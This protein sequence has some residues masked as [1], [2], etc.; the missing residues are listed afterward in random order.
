MAI[1]TIPKQ[2]PK[3]TQEPVKRNE[4]NVKN[5]QKI[6]QEIISNPD[7]KWDKKTRSYK[8][9]KHRPPKP[10]NYMAGD[11]ETDGLFGPFIAA[12]IAIDNNPDNVEFFD[13]LD[14]FMMRAWE[15]RKIGPM[16]MINGAGYDMKYLF[17]QP[18]NNNKKAVPWAYRK[19]RE[20]FKITAINA[21][22]SIV[23]LDIRHPDHEGVLRIRDFSYMVKGSLKRLSSD[24]DVE[25]GK[26]SGEID[27][28]N[29]TFSLD[30]PR[31]KKYLAYDVL[32]TWEVV[33]NFLEAYESVFKFPAKL[34]LTTPA[35]GRYT[36]MRFLKKGEIYFRTPD[37]ISEFVK[38][39]MAGGMV[40]PNLQ[41]PN[42]VFPPEQDWMLAS[43]D[44][45]SHYPAM[46]KLGVP[47]GK[48]FI[49]R[50]YYEGK[51]GFYHIIAD[52]PQDTPITILHKR[53]KGGL[54]YPVGHFET[55][56]TSVEIDE[57]IALGHKVKV[58][59]GLVYPKIV[60][61]FTDFVAECEKGRLKYKGTAMEKVIK[62]IQNSVY[63]G[64]ALRA[65][66]EEICYSEG[67]PEGD[68]WHRY[69]AA[70]GEI[71]ELVWFRDKEVRTAYQKM[72]WASWITAQGRVSL[73]NIGLPYAKEGRL[74]Y[75]DT[76]S[77][78]IIIKK[79][80]EPLFETHPHEYGKFKLEY[81]VSSDDAIFAGPKVYALRNLK[82]PDG[83]YILDKDGNNI[84]EVKS[85]G[86][87]LKGLTY[88]DMYEH[89]HGTDFKQEQQDTASLRL[90]MLRSKENQ[91]HYI[92]RTMTK[93]E[94]VR[95]WEFD[96]EKRKF[97]PKIIFEECGNINY[98]LFKAKNNR[99]EK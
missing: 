95:G 23:G 9:V 44:D 41:E 21:G 45:N 15:L 33:H 20:G 1:P 16:E 99:R 5:G 31:H 26:L 91:L 75:T 52:V 38:H 69:V 53:V 46:M 73:V 11:I 55:Y 61:P 93:A 18:E 43:Y 12:A 30:N 96:M 28:D 64:F 63:G 50:K 22:H 13:T 85:K 76:D 92:T 57:A 32:S 88:R 89:I 54:S 82:G 84:S 49:V 51:P 59:E 68:G 83:K 90:V 65:E 47:G 2:A 39:T 79:G 37:R 78:K 36:W 60:Y 72:E 97:S 80:E 77:V 24:F 70:D 8:E 62:L 66:G 40:R 29:E 3:N 56:A 74:M 87:N 86:M 94:N 14:G 17:D 34:K 71:M 19:V 48:P 35:L 67:M 42:S 81:M 98:D 6:V 58:I 25:H 10:I 7:Y 27:F 4:R